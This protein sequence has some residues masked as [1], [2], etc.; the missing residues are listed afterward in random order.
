MSCVISTRKKRIYFNQLTLRDYNHPSVCSRRINCY[1]PTEHAF[2]RAVSTNTVSVSSNQVRAIC[3]HA[4][5]E[6]AEAADDDAVFGCD[7]CTC[8]ACDVVNTILEY[9]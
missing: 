2:L 8:V 4:A 7:R 1:A 5:V 6:L 3:C 9:I